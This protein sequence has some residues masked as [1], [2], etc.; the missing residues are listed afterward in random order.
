MTVKLRVEYL[1]WVLGEGDFVYSFFSTVSS[2]FEPNGW[3][4]RFRFLLKHLCDHGVV[5][6][7]DLDSFESEVI[8]AKTL[9]NRHYVPEAVYDYEKPWLPIPFDPTEYASDSNTLDHAYCVGDEKYGY[10]RLTDIF[11]LAIQNAKRMKSCVSICDM[12]LSIGEI[13]EMYGVWRKRGRDFW[14]AEL[15]IQVSTIKNI[16][17]FEKLY[18]I[19]DYSKE[20]AREWHNRL[21]SRAKYN[22]KV[23]YVEYM[24]NSTVSEA[25][26]YYDELKKY[27]RELLDSDNFEIV[28][29]DKSFP[30][31]NPDEP[32]RY[33]L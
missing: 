27:Y 19:S 22:G 1:I 25:M 6:Y 7:E 2:L 17:S 10:R 29:L 26:K 9:L 13:E 12:S 23:I 8:L 32:V 20:T 14:K 18:P 16:P 21:S 11:L 31:A 3:G 5:K 33:N 28:F 24:Q 4:S 15:P 30:E